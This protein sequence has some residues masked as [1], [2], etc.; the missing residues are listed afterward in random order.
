M[1]PLCYWVLCFVFFCVLFSCN[2]SNTQK[3]ELAKN[4]KYGAV[5]AFSSPVTPSSLLPNELTSLYEQQI[6]SLMYEPLFKVHSSGEIEG[7]IASGF[8]FSKD[9]NILSLNI[10]KNVLFHNHRVFGDVDRALSAEDVAFS[11]AF[12]C[13]SHP[14]N[15]NASL[16]ENK[17][18]GATEFFEQKNKTLGPDKFNG[19]RV[20]NDSTIDIVLMNQNKQ[21]INVLCHP[22]V[23]MLSYNAYKIL[24]DQMFKEN[25]GTGPFCNPVF[26]ENRIF[27]NRNP[28]YH[29]KDAQN[30]KLPFLDGVEVFLNINPVE[31]FEKGQLNIIQNV[32]PKDIESLFG[33]LE[34]ARNGNTFLHR[35]HVLKDKE[36]TFLLFNESTKPFNDLKIR[37]AFSNKIREE[38]QLEKIYQGSANPDSMFFASVS[39]SF[40]SFSWRDTLEFAHGAYK[41]SQ[42]SALVFSIIKQFNSKGFSIKSKKADL[43]QVLTDGFGSAHLLKLSWVPD[44][45]DKDSFLGLFFSKSNFSKQFGFKDATYDSLYLRS[46]NSSNTLKNQYIAEQRLYSQCHLVPLFSKDL[47]YIAN[48]NMRGLK[49][50]QTGLFDLT[51]VYWKPVNTL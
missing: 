41:S 9:N 18:L 14:K 39:S 20:V 38:L 10:K 1:K 8:R 50:T 17:I 34:G 45:D 15:K 29:Q 40:P 13:S 49:I 22:S 16:F 2:N 44:Y 25:I 51:N 47:I 19:V 27:F 42:D 5:F 46:V 36:F 28:D 7:L 11:I 21:I 35:A 43:N 33:S 4:P 6:S 24:G 37:Q 3:K 12:A 48:I 32:D 30:N 23:P 26:S 31:G